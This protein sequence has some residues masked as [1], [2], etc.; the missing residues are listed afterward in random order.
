MSNT[1]DPM[2]AIIELHNPSWEKIY[3]ENILIDDMALVKIPTKRE[4]KTGEYTVRFKLQGNNHFVVSN[5]IK[6]EEFV[7]NTIEVKA[8]LIEKVDKHVKFRVSAKELH[9]AAAKGLKVAA[10]LVYKSRAFESKKYSNYT[11]VDEKRKN[12]Y[13]TTEKLDTK[14]LDSNGEFIYE[15]DIPDISRPSRC[16]CFGCR[17]SAISK[18]RSVKVGSRYSRL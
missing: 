8:T 11:F 3:E 14:E 10:S 12:F 6:V 17:L 18:C 1:R 4:Y 7:P 9:G 2:P 15:F 13:Q 5:K 16:R